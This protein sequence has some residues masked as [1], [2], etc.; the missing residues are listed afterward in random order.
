MSARVKGSNN[1]MFA[2]A[3]TESNKKLIS[4]FFSKSV[5]LYDANTLTLIARYSKHQDLVK[6]LG[7]SP[8]T[9]IKYNDSGKEFRNKYII[10]NA[11]EMLDK[12]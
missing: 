3:V 5:Y 1:P 2:K 6:Y 7:L 12:R 8:K 9:L 11:W 4:E 10:Y